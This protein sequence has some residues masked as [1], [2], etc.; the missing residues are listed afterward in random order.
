MSDTSNADASPSASDMQQSFNEAAPDVAVEAPAPTA[1]PSST[2]QESSLS[3]TFDQSASQ[4]LV[5]PDLSVTA[6]ARAEIDII[7]QAEAVLAQHDDRWRQLSDRL[8][9]RP[10]AAPSLDMDGSIQR[11]V[12]REYTEY[13][14]EWSEQR[15]AIEYGAINEVIDVRANG[16]TLTNEFSASSNVETTAPEPKPESNPDPSNERQAGE[17]QIHREFRVAEREPSRGIDR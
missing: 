10:I 16:A 13:R 5:A 17:S 9:N 14:R 6:T 1:E 4:T 11:S 15:D 7:D 12:A 3:S 8:S 2:E